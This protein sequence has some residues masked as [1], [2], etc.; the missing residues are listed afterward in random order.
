MRLIYRAGLAAP[1]L[2]EGFLS[3][4][5]SV[6]WKI[7]LNTARYAKPIVSF[8]VYFAKEIKSRIEQGRP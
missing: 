3:V 7:V 5:L 1:V 2:Y 6:Q 4:L 8:A